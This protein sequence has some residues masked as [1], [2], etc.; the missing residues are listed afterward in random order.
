MY[1]LLFLSLH[2]IITF[3]S[4][5]RSSQAIS[6]RKIISAQEFVDRVFALSE[7]S[8]DR[9]PH[10]LVSIMILYP[11]T[12][13]ITVHRRIYIKTINERRQEIWDPV[14]TLPKLLREN[15]ASELQ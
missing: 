9:I 12:T 14:L 6:A 2:P 8:E 1:G 15:P 13:H 10:K 5:S 11:Q 3:S 7:I 4:D